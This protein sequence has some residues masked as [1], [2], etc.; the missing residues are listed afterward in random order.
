M[1]VINKLVLAS[2]TTNASTLYL[3]NKQF[4]T[5]NNIV[6]AYGLT[7]NRAVLTYNT[8]NSTNMTK[9]SGVSVAQE[10]NSDSASLVV[11]S[12]A[13]LWT[14]AGYVGCTACIVPPFAGIP[15]CA[16]CAGALIGAALV[17]I[18]DNNAIN[19]QATGT[20]K[21]NFQ[22]STT[23]PVKRELGGNIF[24]ADPSTIEKGDLV[25]YTLT[26]NG[27]RHNYVYIQDGNAPRT[28]NEMHSLAQSKRGQSS[29]KRDEYEISWISW[30]Y[31]N[32]NE[33]L[34]RNWFNQLMSAD[35]QDWFGDHVAAVMAMGPT[36]K[37]CISAVYP[38]QGNA[39]HGEIYTNNYGGIDSFCN[40]DSDNFDSGATCTGWLDESSGASWGCVV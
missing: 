12:A 30:S 39:F 9:R 22:A 16:I 13:G 8:Y 7:V 29:Y 27:K 17:L 14:Y 6:S 24:N 23:Y 11:T 28:A 37:Y 15:A 26:V 36:T 18:A 33:E 31:D 10:F 40:A 20:Y 19:S 34:S 25:G 3:S 1:R 32:N 4:E 38:G 2:A 5:G 21:V 35:S